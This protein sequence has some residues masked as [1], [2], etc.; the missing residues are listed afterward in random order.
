MKTKDL[1]VWQRERLVESIAGTSVK[2]ATLEPE[3][4][5]DVYL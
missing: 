5:E 2:Q 1:E 4:N 3:W